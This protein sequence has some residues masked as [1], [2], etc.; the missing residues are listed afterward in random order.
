M[1]KKIQTAEKGTKAVRE[2]VKLS[3]QTFAGNLA[4]EKTRRAIPPGR[5]INFNYFA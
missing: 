4:G 5:Y 2:I 3:T 1:I